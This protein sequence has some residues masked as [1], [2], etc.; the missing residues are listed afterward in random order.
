M[1]RVRVVAIIPARMASSRF[2]GKPLLKVAGLPMIEHVRRRTVLCGRFS[3]VVVATC[4]AEIAEVVRGY[5][6]MCLMTS[7]THP[8][9]SDRVAEA[10][11]QLACTHVVNVQ[12][13]EIL[14]RPDDLSRL[15]DAITEAPAVPAWNAVA[16]IRRPEE[17]H[18][19]SVVKCAISGSG[20]MMFCVREFSRIP[21]D[22]GGGFEPIRIVLGILGYRRDFLDRY[23]MLARTP[24]EQAEAID[25]SRIL[26][27][28]IPLHS[29]EFAE[30]YPGINEPR[31][32]ALV[33]HYLQKDSAQQAI[34]RQV[35]EFVTERL[36][37]PRPVAEGVR[38]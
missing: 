28:D 19:R 1:S 18:D 16:R 20:R 26:E 24:L 23:P 29:V 33:E 22:A 7:P 12:G 30:G 5:G 8:G 9:A 21:L 32:V 14:V 3:E 17:L 13:D 10:A 15:L 25:Q 27:H 6:G 35:L 38:G 4:D 2:P 31:E 11:R 37:Q 36:P 34:L